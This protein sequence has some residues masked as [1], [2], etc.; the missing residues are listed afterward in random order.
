MQHFWMFLRLFAGIQGH[1][2][3]H[4]FC[5]H[6]SHTPSQSSCGSRRLWE[7][8]PDKKYQQHNKHSAFVVEENVTRGELW[9]LLPSTNRRSEGAVHAGAGWRSRIKQPHLSIVFQVYRGK[10]STEQTAPALFDVLKPLSS[11]FFQRKSLERDSCS[12]CFLICR[13]ILIDKAGI[14]NGSAVFKLQNQF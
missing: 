7:E 10:R 11:S 3:L 5:S 6:C 2:F 1:F 8:K 14:L 4:F 13:P 12:I 9:F